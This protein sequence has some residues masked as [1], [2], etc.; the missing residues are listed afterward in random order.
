MKIKL[1]VQSSVTDEVTEVSEATVIGALFNFDAAL[2]W[3]TLH[4]TL[5]GEPH[6]VTYTRVRE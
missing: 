1:K 6:E 5:L 3:V 2:E 4:T